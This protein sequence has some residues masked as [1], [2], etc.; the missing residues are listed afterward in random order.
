[1][2]GQSYNLEVS[3]IGFGDKLLGGLLSEQGEVVCEEDCVQDNVLD[4]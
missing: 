3:V 1:M 2:E 4:K